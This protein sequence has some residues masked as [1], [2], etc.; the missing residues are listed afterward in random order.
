MSHA[1]NVRNHRAGFGI[2]VMTLITLDTV[3]VKVVEQSFE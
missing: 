2:G 1:L 3:N